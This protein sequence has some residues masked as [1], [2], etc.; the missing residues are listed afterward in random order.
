MNAENNLDQNESGYAKTMRGEVV[1]KNVSFPYEGHK[2]ALQ[3][4]S[5]QVHPGQTVAIVGQTGSGKTTLVRLINRTYDPKQGQVLIDGVDLRAWK[6]DALRSQISIIE[7]DIFLFSKSIY[8]NIAFGKPGATR[9]EVSRL[10][11]ALRHTNLSWIWRMVTIPSLANGA[12][13]FLEV[14]GNV[15]P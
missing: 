7:Q 5:F 4:I 15:S 14:N 9:E 10:P 11:K 1:F 12:Q 3:D 2:S 8:D 6:L 13:R